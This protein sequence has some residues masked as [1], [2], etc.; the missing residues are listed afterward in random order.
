MALIY[1]VQS[2]SELE[3]SAGY[4]SGLLEGGHNRLLVTFAE[5]QGKAQT[6]FRKRSGPVSRRKPIAAP[7]A[8]PKPRM[9]KK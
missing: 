8:N 1:L 9:S 2:S 7:K 6:I 4:S 3:G 5:Y